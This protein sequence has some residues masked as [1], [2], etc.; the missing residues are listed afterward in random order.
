MPTPNKKQKDLLE[1]ARRGGGDD[2]LMLLDK[3]TELEDKVEE[4]EESIVDQGI[5]TDLEKKMALL[6]ENL[7]KDKAI[8]DIIGK[9]ATKLAVKMAIL[10]K[11]EKGEPGD[12]GH[13][14]TVTELRELIIPLIPEPAHG[15]DG[16]D[17]DEEK[18]IEGVL[19][20]IKLP[21]F[22]ETVL[23]TPEQLRDKLESLKD[24]ARLDKSAIKNLQ[25]DLD[26]LKEMIRSVSLK[27]AGGGGG[28]PNANAVQ[29]HY[30]TGDGTRS[31]YVPK[32]R[33]ALMLIGTEGPIMF[34]RTTDW[35]TAGNTLALNAALND[36][37][38]QEYVFLYVK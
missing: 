13:T 20:K 19:A 24:E 21:E 28:G 3:I 6:G 15:I 16:Q 11:G 25:E 4:L 33:S 36:S 5:A 7:K 38:G 26:K 1:L 10:E 14:P 8:E 17:A 29:V 34:K 12:N 23:D 30:F 27:G 35:T 32:H 22:K 31:Y 37:V 9:V 2:S 18:I